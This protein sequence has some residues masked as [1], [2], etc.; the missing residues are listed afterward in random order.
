MIVATRDGYF[1]ATAR[2]LRM[3]HLG[4]RAARPD[5]WC[6]NHM[7]EM[8]IARP[9]IAKGVSRRHPIHIALIGRADV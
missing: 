5:C 4:R 7:I 1:V 8:R 3:W 6:R 9:T 2:I